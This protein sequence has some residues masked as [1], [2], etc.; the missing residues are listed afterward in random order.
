MPDLSP[1]IV[2]PA[3]PRFHTAKI[4]PRYLPNPNGKA[5]Q[6]VASFDFINENIAGAC[7]IIGMLI[8]STTIQGSVWQLAASVCWFTMIVRKKCWG[9]V[10]FNVA[11]VVVALV[12]I[13][14][15]W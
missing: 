15:A 5:W 2:H 14:R 12:N 9:I 3:D 11:L 8:G 1:V 10:P 6:L 13:W 7:A 4:F